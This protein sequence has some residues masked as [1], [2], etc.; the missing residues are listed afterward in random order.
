MELAGQTAL[1]SVE[2]NQLQLPLM[3]PNTPV[4]KLC[5]KSDPMCYTVHILTLNNVGY[6]PSYNKRLNF[7]NSQLAS[8]HI[9]GPSLIIC[10]N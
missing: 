2:I 7:F 4:Q 5:Q 3:S 8:L 10:I 9:S 6:V 1:F